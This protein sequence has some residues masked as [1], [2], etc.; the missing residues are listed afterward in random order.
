MVK[1]FGQAF[2][3]T[4]KPGWNQDEVMTTERAGAGARFG[5][6]GSVRLRICLCAASTPYCYCSL[7]SY[8]CICLFDFAYLYN[9]QYVPPGGWQGR[10]PQLLM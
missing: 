9:L 10:P 2:D 7:L 5:L 3:E 8:F 4:V 1:P 6:C